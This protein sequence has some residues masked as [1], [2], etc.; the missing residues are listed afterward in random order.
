MEISIRNCDFCKTLLM[1]LVVFCHSIDFWTGVW[2]TRNPVFTSKALSIIAD[3]IGNFHIYG[4]VLISG[5]IFYY[6]KFEKNN[7]KCFRQFIIKKIKRLIIPYAFAS[8]TC[9][10]PA[11]I[12]Y[13]DCSIKDI[14]TKYILGIDPAQLWFLLML[15]FVFAIFWQLSD[16][17]KNKIFI[18]NL[19]LLLLYALSSFASRIIPN[20]YQVLTSLQYLVYFYLGFL[21][22]KYQNKIKNIKYLSLITA[23]IYIILFVIRRIYIDFFSIHILLKFIL[24]YFLHIFGAL[25]SFFMLQHLANIVTFKNCYLFKELGKQS[26]TIYLF[27][28]QIVY[29]LI[30]LLNGKI[31]PYLHSIINFIVSIIFSFALS[32]ILRRHKVTRFLIGEKSNNI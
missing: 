22:R 14:L 23:T 7:Y 26:M 25:M 10:I 11:F 18:T 12:Y 30:S 9:A 27:N 19:I 24:N 20:V 3:F 8:L 5:Y 6:M 17:A 15:F 29:F 31:N 28:Q 21:L 1:I 13:F 4:F 32:K 16:I 2:F